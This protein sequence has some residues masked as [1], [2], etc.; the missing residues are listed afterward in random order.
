MSENNYLLTA[1]ELDSIENTSLEIEDEGTVFA[2]GCG[3]AI[4]ALVGGIMGALSGNV[5]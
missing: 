2:A 1:E 4:P 5:Y 3:W